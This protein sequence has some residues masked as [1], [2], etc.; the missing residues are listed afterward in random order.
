M[1]IGIR[2]LACGHSWDATHR[3]VIPGTS[4]VPYKNIFPPNFSSMEVRE[5]AFIL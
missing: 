2:K 1:G 4:C 5:A 3:E